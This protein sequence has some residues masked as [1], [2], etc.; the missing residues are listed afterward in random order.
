MCLP[1]DSLLQ[2]YT[3]SIQCRY[4]KIRTVFKLSRPYFSK[5][6]FNKVSHG[7]QK[8]VVNNIKQ[9][10]TASGFIS[11]CGKY[12]NPSINHCL[13]CLPS[14]FHY[15]SLNAV[16]TYFL[17][18]F[19][20]RLPL[21]H[22]LLRH[23]PECTQQGVAPHCGQHN[24]CNTCC[25]ANPMDRYNDLHRHQTA[26]KSICL[27]DFNTEHRALAEFQFNVFG[28]VKTFNRSWF[29]LVLLLT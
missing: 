7:R 2:R 27:V 18:V 15:T 3:T 21:V 4:I 14:Q 5:A 17:P 12:K 9:Q 6:S 29:G 25:Y 8:L 16:Y 22:G 28:L 19:C 26:N 1:T 23:R 24:G 13:S 20:N 11:F 10:L